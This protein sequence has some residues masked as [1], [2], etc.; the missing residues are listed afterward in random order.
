MMNSEKVSINNEKVDDSDESI[1]ERARKTVNAI[2]E[3]ET[4]NLAE[5]FK[6]NEED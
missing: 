6:V 4:N 1:I 3:R 2:K 5:R